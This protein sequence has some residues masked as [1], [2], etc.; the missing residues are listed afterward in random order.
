MF[1]MLGNPSQ[2]FWTKIP[3]LLAKVPMNPD[4]EQKKN[5]M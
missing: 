1:Y 2:N 4:K 3:S 5:Y